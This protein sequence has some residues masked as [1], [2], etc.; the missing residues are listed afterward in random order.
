MGGPD[1]ETNWIYLTP[2]EHVVAHHCLA[3]AYPENEKLNSGFNVADL[4]NYDCYRYMMR[5]HDLGQCLEAT[6]KKKETIEKIMLLCNA[7]QTMNIDA[8]PVTKT[9]DGKRIKRNKK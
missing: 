2:R 6:K 3:P 7:I 8:I 4:K 5:I 9:G 1:I